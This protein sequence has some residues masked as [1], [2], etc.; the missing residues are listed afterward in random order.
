[1][2]PITLLQ[3]SLLVE[4]FSIIFIVAAE[5]FKHG[6]HREPQGAAEKIAKYYITRLKSIK[7]KDYKLNMNYSL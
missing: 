4:C 6:E 1:M 5:K 7:I 2:L 3:F